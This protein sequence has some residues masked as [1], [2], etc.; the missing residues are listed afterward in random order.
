MTGA[1]MRGARPDR[2][3][4]AVALKR[5]GS[6]LDVAA[7]EALIA[8]V[9]AAPAEI[10]SSWHAL[11]AE[12]TPTELAAELEA[13]KSALAVDH[14]DGVQPEDFKRMPRA[15]RLMLLREKLAEQG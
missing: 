14:R 12:P 13:F 3:R 7:V 2:D 11:V 9:L 1:E 10:G 4:L 6:A 5:A 15:E 8:G